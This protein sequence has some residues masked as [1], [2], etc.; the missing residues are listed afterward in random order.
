MEF[1]EEAIPAEYKR[2]STPHRGSR[3]P[4]THRRLRISDALILAKALRKDAKHLSGYVGWT[5]WSDQWNLKEV[6]EFVGQRVNDEAPREHFLFFLGEEFVGMGSLAPVG[7][8]DEIQVALWVASKHQGNGIGSRIVATLEWYA[9]EAIGYSRIFYQHDSSNESS[10]KLPQKLGFVFSHTFDEEVTARNE[11]GFWY[12][13]VKER[14][15]DLPPAI[16]Q[17]ADLDQFMKVRHEVV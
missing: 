3:F 7:Q 2:L 5:Q 17:G 8:L 6:Q 4:L 9:F 16:L 12:S 14:P 13:W 1:T 15:F 10:K 11:T